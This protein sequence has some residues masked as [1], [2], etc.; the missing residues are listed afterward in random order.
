MPPA[1]SSVRELVTIKSA[2]N[3]DFIVQLSTIK[4]LKDNLLSLNILI[5]DFTRQFFWLN[6][7]IFIDSIFF[8]YFPNAVIIE[9]INN[10]IIG[11]DLP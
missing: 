3:L 1:K 7:L 2:C 6:Y 10:N 9:S 4:F 5:L 8:Y 11:F